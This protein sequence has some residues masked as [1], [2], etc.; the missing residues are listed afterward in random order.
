MRRGGEREVERVEAGRAE[1]RRL[2]ELRADAEERPEV[3]LGVVPHRL[4]LV[5]E[6]LDLSLSLS[7]LLLAAVVR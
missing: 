6:L 4:V 2:V 1:R 7:L 3:V 5:D